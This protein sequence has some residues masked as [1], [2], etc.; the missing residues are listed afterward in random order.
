MLVVA[1][2]VEE[3]VIKCT[4]SSASTSASGEAYSA[5]L[6]AKRARHRAELDDDDF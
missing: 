1:Y 2:A 4:L 6:A 5:W 3:E